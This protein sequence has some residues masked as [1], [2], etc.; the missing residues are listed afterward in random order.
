LVSESFPSLKELEKTDER[1]KE[2]SA[3][4]RERTTYLKNLEQ[5]RQ[6]AGKE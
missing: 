6:Q 1:L 3:V 4:L 5:E 2:V